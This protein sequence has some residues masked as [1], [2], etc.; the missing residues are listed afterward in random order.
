[1][2]KR[3]ISGNQA[4]LVYLGIGSNLGYRK[5]N[6][7]KAKFR[8][9]QLNIEI[10][11]CSNYYESL[12]WPNSKHPKFLNIVIKI[13]TL[14]EPVKLLE[15]CKK[16]EIELGRKKTSKNAPRECDIDIIDYNNKIINSDIILPHPRMSSRNF[17]LFPLFQL[18]KNWHHP[19]SKLPIKTLISLLRERDISSIKLI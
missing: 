8:L 3:D 17:V 4:S 15:I 18:D 16:I 14:L 10:I 9:S 5:N 19:V 11:K 13:K 6:I 12:S 2:I 1:M 7:E